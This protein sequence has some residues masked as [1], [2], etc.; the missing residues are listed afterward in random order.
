MTFMT[1]IFITLIFLL[2]MATTSF[3]E[4]FGNTETSAWADTPIGRFECNST[5]DHRQVLSIGGKE[6]YRTS[7]HLVGRMGEAGAKLLSQGIYLNPRTSFDS[8]CPNSIYSG[9][10]VTPFMSSESF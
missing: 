7:D 2:G 5:M 6:I 3:A 1:R 8:S 4:N 10:P 9:N